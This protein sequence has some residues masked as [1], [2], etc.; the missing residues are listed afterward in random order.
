MTRCFA[1]FPRPLP[2]CA[3]GPAS[4]VAVIY[5]AE[6]LLPGFRPLLTG[7]AAWFMKIA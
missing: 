5:N 6:S 7:R 4:L 2:T 1:I 3:A